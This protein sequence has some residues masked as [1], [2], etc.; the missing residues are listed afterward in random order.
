MNPNEIEVYGTIGKDVR[1]ATVKAQLA[2]ADQTQELVARFDSEGGSVFEG[3][4]L[5]DAFA[6]YPGP[7]RAIIAS[8]AFSIASFVAMAFDQIDM[9]PN[10]YLMIHNPSQPVDGDDEAH[11]QSA[12]LLADLKGRMVQAYAQRSRKSPDEVLALMKAET[13]L[14]AE[15]AVAQ[16]FASSVAIGPRIASRI[17]AKLNQLPLRVVASLRNDAPESGAESA[18]EKTMPEAVKPDAPASLEDIEAKFPKMGP[19]FI[20]AC[21]R[22]K[23]PMASVATAAVDE[24]MAENAN[25]QKQIEAMKQE[26]AAAQ[27]G[28]APAASEEAPAADPPAAEGEVPVEEDPPAPTATAVA[29]RRGAAPVARSQSA[30]PQASARKQWADAV[31]SFRAKGLTPSKAAV[32]ANKE[33]PGLQAQVVAEANG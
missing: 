21:L 3:F 28:A 22:K 14:S 27:A 30:P 17:V 9:A 24:V 23:L 2:V 4:A 32:A 20:V 13:F 33:F 8:S 6:A 15:E 19:G 12:T 11:A 16:G 5:Y 26:L 10:G 1:A 31:A 25:L 18:A 7:K 29:K